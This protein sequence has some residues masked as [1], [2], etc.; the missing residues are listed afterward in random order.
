MEPIDYRALIQ[1]RKAKDRRPIVR[2]VI[3]LDPE[4]YAELEEAQ[5][6]LREQRAADDDERAPAADPRMGALSPRLQAEA[7]VAEIEQRIAAVSI[8]GVFKAPTSAKQAELNDR[9]E[10]ARED[11]PDGFNVAIMQ[12]AREVILLTLEHFEGPDRKRL[13][14]DRSDLEAML[15]TWSH[16][17]VIGLGN[18]IT[19]ASVEVHDAPKSVRLSLNSRHSAA[20]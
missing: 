13:D 3:C 6:E 8:I 10:K 20:T 19:R 9:L 11:N 14:L 17:E 18:L 7:R 2:H 5:Q 4:L 16:G 1:D 12:H 15:D